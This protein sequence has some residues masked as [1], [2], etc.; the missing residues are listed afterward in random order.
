MRMADPVENAWS[1]GVPPAVDGPG[2][3]VTIVIVGFNTREVILRCLE[4]V[5][6][7]TAGVDFEV[8]VVDN[9]SK[10]GSSDAIAERF[11]RARLIRS[12][13][14]LGFGQA[15]NLAARSARGRYLLLLNPDTVVLAGAVQRIVAFADRHPEAGIYGGRTLFAD[16]S[17]N[18][19]SCW[20][21]ATLWSTFC[22]ALG[23]SVAFRD[24]RLF[25]RESLGWWKRD[26]VR[27]VDIVT[28]CFLLIPLGLWRRLGG[29]SPA[30]F[31]YGEEVDLC[32]RA[33][34]L[35]VQPVVTPEAT[36]IHLGGASEPVFADKLVRVLTARARLMRLHWSPW[37][38][39][40]GVR[41]SALG[42]GNRYL[43]GRL[44]RALGMRVD[45]EKV[46]GWGAAWHRRAEWMREAP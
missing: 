10:D 28:G 19:S 36:L 34:K 31:M 11:P 1:P 27:P 2:A 33:R 13:R 43:F 21:Q 40:L 37:K 29:F 17:L 18:P 8:I 12:A 16:G 35:G 7:E 23:L 44:L 41:L 9:D 30:F 25:D 39:A 14:N 45:A 26:S 42:Y 38:A 46:I 32:L 6:R 4:S 24:S 20:G 15:N 5:Y 22:R 3:D